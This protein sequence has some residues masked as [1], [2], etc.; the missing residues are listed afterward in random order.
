M[1]P[2]PENTPCWQVSERPREICS[3]ANLGSCQTERG[4]CLLQMAVLLFLQSGAPVGVLGSRA[5]E[6]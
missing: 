6:T 2:T 4:V 1:A 5:P 3:S